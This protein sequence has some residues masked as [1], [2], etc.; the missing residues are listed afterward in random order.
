M[1]T[2]RELIYR[3]HFYQFVSI[4]AQDLQIPGQRSRI[5]AH[6]DHFLRR[7]RASVAGSQLT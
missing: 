2:H 4:G 5:A 1:N 7:H 3:L 6:I